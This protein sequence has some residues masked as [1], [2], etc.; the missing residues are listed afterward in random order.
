MWGRRAQSKRRTGLLAAIVLAGLVGLFGT[1]TV[2][3]TAVIERAHP[4]AGRFIPVTGGV[5]H[6]AE[7]GS[8]S[9]P[10]VVL[11]HGAA[12]N[13][14]DLENALGERLAPRH[15]LLF[16][17]RPGHG[18]SA[19]ATDQNPSSLRSEAARLHEALQGLGVT[20]AVVVGHSWGGALAAAYALDH[21]Q[22]VTGLV[23]LAPVAYAWM[24]RVPW[25]Y[26]L[27]ATPL[28]GPVFAH[29]FALPVGW[30]A[31]PS[32]LRLVFWPQTPPPDYLDRSAGLLSFRPREFLATAREVT[33]LKDFGAGQVDRYPALQV[34]TVIIAGDRDVIVSPNDHAR[35]LAAAL[36]QARLVMLPGVGH[37]PHYVA[38][39][40][41]VEAI[42]NMASTAHPRES[43]DP[44]PQQRSPN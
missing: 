40:A 14:R 3:G 30:V 22:N 21:P 29:L 31:A 20:R 43:G 12:A 35:R 5:L 1:A 15:R 24:G 27:G 16:I 41:V 18:W 32:G 6:V 37:M 17:D 28:V 33:G 13:L 4:P 42:A 36:P 8:P 25:F 44:G 2:I 10:P 23:L 19:S 39:D 7:K 34:P 38:T 11:I 9:A 26:Q